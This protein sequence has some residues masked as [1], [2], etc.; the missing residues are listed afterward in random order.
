[1]RFLRKK[2]INHTIKFNESE[3]HD[4]CHVVEDPNSTLIMSPKTTMVH[5]AMTT[6]YCSICK[7][8]FTF[9]KDENGKWIDCEL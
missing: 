4:C 3:N 6:G 5:P 8:F 9:T 1:V 7:G 2:C